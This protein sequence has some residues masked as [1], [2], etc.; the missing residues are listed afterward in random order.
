MQQAWTPDE[1]DAERLAPRAKFR[2]GLYGNPGIEMRD[3]A[4]LV[5]R[6]LGLAE[7]PD[8]EFP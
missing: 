2:D 8:E 6:L 5:R 7:L 1:M 4:L 3:H